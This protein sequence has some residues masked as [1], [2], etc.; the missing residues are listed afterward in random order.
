MNKKHYFISHNI[1]LDAAESKLYG[2]ITDD[3]ITI[4]TS[5]AVTVNNHKFCIIG[6]TFEEMELNEIWKIN[7]FNVDPVT[8]KSFLSSLEH[9]KYPFYGIS[10]H[11]EKNAFEW[12][13][14]KNIPHTANAILATQYFSNFFVNQCRKN[15]NKFPD[16]IM[17]NDHLIQNFNPFFTG[18]DAGSNFIQSY[19]FQSTTEDDGK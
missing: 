15:D 7:S 12:V 2:D 19:L 11:P 14:G 8:K 13:E 6:S 10:F 16:K 1:S 5:Q 4:L 17:E 3:I 9:K 18:K